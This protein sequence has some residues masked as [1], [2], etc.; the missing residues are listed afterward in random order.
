MISR[1]A[2]V[3]TAAGIAAGAA[4]PAR[5][6]SPA[7]PRTGNGPV[8]LTLPAPG[9]P[10][11]LGAITLRLVDTGRRDP[12]VP[13]RP[14]RELMV[15][16]RY[17]ARAAT[18]E[19]HPRAPHMEP[20]A[21]AGFDALNNLTGVPAGTVD[22]AAT[23]SHAHTAAPAETAG[24]PFPVV[25]YS[26]GVVD[27]RTWATT[28]TDDL[29][30]RG[31]VVVTVDHTYEATAV[32]FP[33][34][35]VEHSVVPAVFEA[36]GG[37]PERVRALLEKTVAVRVADTRFVLDALPSALPAALRRVA[38]LSRTGMFGQSAGGFTALQTMEED[39]RLLAGADLDGV[40]AFVQEDSEPGHLSSVARNGLDRPFLLMGDADNGLA[41]VP[42]WA[43]LA[44]HSTGPHRCLTLPGSA[45]ATYTDAE[46]LVPQIA[47]AHCLPASVVTDNIGTASPARALAATHAAL[48]GLF[49][50]ALGGRDRSRG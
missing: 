32:E 49:G 17:P 12:W 33:G 41:T 35:R 21:A 1:R 9:G 14:Y 30:S 10:Y 25:L 44:A 26:P 27:P 50:A 3:L 47:R 20:G 11:A 2:L 39:R 16:V 5:A 37:D 19:A 15:G 45:H 48:A 28:L 7:A 46:P 31:H 42:S 36:T 24:G 38:D 29:A 13:R 6:A 34:G 43:A 18:A 22:W 8:R 40:L 4:T 23:V